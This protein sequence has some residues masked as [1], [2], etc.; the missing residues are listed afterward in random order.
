MIKINQEYSFVCQFCKTL[1]TRATAAEEYF[2]PCQVSM[3]ELFSKVVNPLMHNVPK[4]SD[5]L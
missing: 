1:V 2:R 5:T 4:W 3:I